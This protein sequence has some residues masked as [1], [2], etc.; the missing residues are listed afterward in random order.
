MRH[1][2]RYD[3]FRAEMISPNTIGEYSI[4]RFDVTPEQA[5]NARLVGLV[6]SFASGI[7]RYSDF[8]SGTY[9]R[10]VKGSALLMTD[11]PDE[12]RDHEWPLTHAYGHVLITGLGLGIVAMGCARDKDVT[13]V[14]VVEKSGEVIELVC[15]HIYH[16]KLTVV[17]ADAFEWEPPPDTHFNIAWHDIWPT[18]C[19]DNLIEME[20]LRQHYSPYI[21]PSVQ[22]CWNEAQC[23]QMERNEQQ[24]GW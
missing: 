11:T 18:M 13:S 4:E 9:T 14:T 8:E 10:L 6:Q 17:H 12:I 3:R 16:D 20:A 15:P 1:K 24:G 21:A 22:R 19:S 23:M 5:E 7:H 2:L